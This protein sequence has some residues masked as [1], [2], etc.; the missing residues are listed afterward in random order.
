MSVYVD[1]SEFLDRP[2]RTG[3]QRVTAELCA[4]WPD[5]TE[6]IP[7]R[8]TRD[9]RMVRLSGDTV[10]TIKDYFRSPADHV[11]ECLTRIREIVELS[12]TSPHVPLVRG[13]SLVCSELFCDP[14]RI[15]FYESRAPELHSC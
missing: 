11:A 7:V 3:I 8:I 9:T 10:S 2:L 15:Y 5:P 1:L 6:L 12:E 14:G 13:D 4:Q